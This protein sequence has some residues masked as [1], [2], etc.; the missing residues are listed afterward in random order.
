M[1]A[2]GQGTLKLAQKPPGGAQKSLN[3]NRVG[4]FISRGWFGLFLVGVCWPLNWALPG[5]R[6][7]YLF[8]PLWLGYILVV[9]SIVLTRSGTSLR[10]R[11]LKN[12]IL[13][14]VTSAPVW[15]IFELINSRTAN[16]EY[17]GGESF[18]QLEY[19]LLSTLSF[20]TVMP[21]VFETAE[22][23]RTFRW[24][25][26][27]ASGFRISNQTAVGIGLFFG[28]LLMLMLTFIWPKYCYPFVWTSL[29][30]I[31]ESVNR[32]LG[33][34]H[35]IEK[36]QAGD[37]RPVLSL[38]LGALICGFFWEMWNFY[39][40]PKWVYHTPG[41]QFFHIFEMPLLGYGGYIPF[42]LELYGL[43]NLVRSNPPALRI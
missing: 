38:A 17:L 28:G 5:M 21:A 16:W 43:Q 34:P 29:A 6:T 9:D 22:L 25:E 35:L 20:S 3:R 11:S 7:A 10:S 36:L 4:A 1:F 8:F 12:F 41:A 39:S 32:W 2:E 30:L 14:F 31:L 15:W 27:R 37:W 13:L 26:R 19:Y 42:A 33:R 40:Y 18:S 24:V 23:V